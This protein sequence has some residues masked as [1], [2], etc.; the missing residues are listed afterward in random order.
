[1][2]VLNYL[3][4]LSICLLVAIVLEG[5]FTLGVAF[6]FYAYTTIGWIVQACIVIICLKIAAYR[7]VSDKDDLFM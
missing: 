7:W 3:A 6:H 2:S 1:M 5:I 4:K